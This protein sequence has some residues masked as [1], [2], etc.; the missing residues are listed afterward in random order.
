MAME[1]FV[2]RRSPFPSRRFCQ[3]SKLK[4]ISKREFVPNATIASSFLKG[5]CVVR[6]YGSIY[7]WSFLFRG[8]WSF[9]SC[10]LYSQWDTLC[11]SPAPIPTRIKATLAIETVVWCGVKVL[12]LIPA[13][14]KS[15]CVDSTIFMQDVIPLH[16]ATTAK[17][18]LNLHFGNGRIISHHFQT[19]WPRSPDLNPCDFCL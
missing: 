7:R 11:I 9:G 3:Y 1:N 19:A 16:I 8:D 6:V 18:L 2:D 13:L 10:K 12:K 17:K 15:G 4:D 14:E 5:H